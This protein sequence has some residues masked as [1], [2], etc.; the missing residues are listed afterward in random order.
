VSLPLLS[1]EALPLGL[2]IIGFAGR[3]ADL[4]A[5]AAALQDLIRGAG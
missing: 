2:Q 1:A 5:I 3:D 4:F